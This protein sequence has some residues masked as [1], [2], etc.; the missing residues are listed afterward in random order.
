MILRRERVSRLQSI[1]IMD[2][3]DG[4]RLCVFLKSRGN[5]LM[6]HMQNTEMFANTVPPCL[7]STFLSKVLLFPLRFIK[8]KIP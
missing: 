7:G 4:L 2:I 3:L 8:V 6:A 5:L 1:A